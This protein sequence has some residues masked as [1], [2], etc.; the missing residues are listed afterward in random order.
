MQINIETSS[1]YLF[2]PD[3]LRDFADTLEAILAEENDDRE[4][5]HQQRIYQMLDMLE[6]LTEAATAAFAAR[7]AEKA[8]AR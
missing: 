3:N 5:V 4:S 2:R 7:R 8:A 1:S 6:V